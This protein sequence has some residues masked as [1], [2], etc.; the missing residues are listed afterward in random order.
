M[1]MTQSEI[2]VEDSVTRHLTGVPICHIC[3]YCNCISVT[4]IAF[5]NTIETIS[6][7][8]VCVVNSRTF[9]STSI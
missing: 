3:N 5:H 9:G 2:S 6:Y 1:M 7:Y 8:S 4:T